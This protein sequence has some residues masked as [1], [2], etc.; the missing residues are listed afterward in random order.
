MS[1]KF[2][3]RCY[4]VEFTIS[5]DDFK[6]FQKAKNR[7]TYIKKL[8]K[9]HGLFSYHS[10]DSDEMSGENIII[11]YTVNIEDSVVRKIMGEMAM[12]SLKFLSK[13]DRELINLLIF[14][15]RSLRDVAKLYGVNHNT[16]Q[17]K[18]QRILAYLKNI[19]KI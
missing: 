10:L 2:S 11:D 7:E 18:K 1:K 14:E 16:I 5:E 4:G 15:N 8:K 12:D 13:E 9:K 17:K 19:L 6:A 3:V